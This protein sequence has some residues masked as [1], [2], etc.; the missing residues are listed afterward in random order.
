M[1]DQALHFRDKR[2]LALIRDFTLSD[3]VTLGNAVSGASCILLCL[4]Y[5]E[6]DEYHPYLVAAFVL[7]PFALLCD[8]LDG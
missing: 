5:L 1:T 3:F 2:T 8:I 6:N 4:N 7:L